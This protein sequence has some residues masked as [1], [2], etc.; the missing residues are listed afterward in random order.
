MRRPSVLLFAVLLLACGGAAPRQRVD[1]PEDLPARRY[2]VPADVGRLVVDAAAFADFARGVRAELEGELARYDIRA[3][4]PL[5]ERL[6]VLALLDALDDRWAEAV[7]RLDAIAAVEEDARA[8]AMTGLTIRVWADARA[9]GGDGAP[10]FRAALE[11]KLAA[12]SVAELREPLTMLRAMGR[13]FSPE[14]CRQ[15]VD[16]NVGPEARAGAVS[17]ESVHA[18]AFQRYAVVRLVPVGRD[19][20]QVLDAHGI[21]A[22][23]GRP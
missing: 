4:E 11:R 12:L 14:V 23:D 7:A 5:K 10:A 13:T 15:L 9:H 6:F 1:R 3:A 21:V 17:L 2:A 22:A 19:I 20:D 8:R 18:I 16:E